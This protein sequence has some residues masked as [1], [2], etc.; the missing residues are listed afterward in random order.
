MR[1]FSFDRDAGW[2]MTHF[3]SVHVMESPIHRGAGPCQMACF[4]LGPGGVVGYHQASDAGRV[5]AVSHV[6]RS[7]TAGAAGHTH[8]HR[9]H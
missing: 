2:E 4:Q 8:A 6:S 7:W 9:P 1:L 5:A 3:G